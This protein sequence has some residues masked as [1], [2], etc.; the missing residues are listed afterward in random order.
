MYDTLTRKTAAADRAAMPP[1][2]A[3]RTRVRRSSE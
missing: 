2:I 1:S 3:A